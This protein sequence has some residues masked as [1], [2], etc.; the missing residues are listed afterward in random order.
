M[1]L[2]ITNTYA[3]QLAILVQG[4]RRIFLNWA[5][6]SKTMKEIESNITNCKERGKKVS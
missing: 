3:V 5:V 1:L 4:D 2:L 6:N